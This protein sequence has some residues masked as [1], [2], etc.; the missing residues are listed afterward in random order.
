LSLSV[1]G[2]PAPIYWL[3]NSNGVQQVAFQ[4]PCE[5]APGAATVAV[6]NGS[7]TATIPGVQAL[8]AQPGMFTSAGPGATLYGTVIRPDGSYVSPSNFAQ[9]G[10]TDYLVATGLGLPTPAPKT[11]STGNGETIPPNQVLVGVNNN[12]VPVV[13]VQYVPG[14]IGVYYIGFQLSN[15]NLSPGPNQPLEL[16]VCTAGCGTSNP[17]YATDGQTALIAGV[18]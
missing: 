11:G 15:P 7:G 3:S 6:T 8:A 17:Q 9:R 12:G 13:S 5:T 16:W 2:I 18:Q 10:E 14:A 4:T 1:N